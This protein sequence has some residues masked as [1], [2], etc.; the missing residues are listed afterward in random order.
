MLGRL[1][2]VVLQ[3]E[4]TLSVT[5]YNDFFALEFTADTVRCVSE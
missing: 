1:N 5:M 4:A 3:P 2:D